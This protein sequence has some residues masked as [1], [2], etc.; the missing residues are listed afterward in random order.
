MLPFADRIRVVLVNTSAPGNIG[1][2]A[3]AMKTMGLSRLV[4]VAPDTY[5]HPEATWMAA[6]AGDVLEAAERVD[7]VADAIAG[8][9]LVIGT[10]ARDRRL[11]WPQKDAREMAAGLLGAG[12]EE[13]I[14]LLFGREDRG[15]SNEELQQCHWHVSIPANPDYGV[16]NIAQAVQILC[17]EIRM[18]WLSAEPAPAEQEWDVPWASAEEVEGFQ[19]HLE[20]TLLDIGFL[21]PERPRQLM[22]RLRRLFTRTRLD[23]M[24]VNILRGVLALVQKGLNKG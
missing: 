14:A 23:K 12:E 17:Y 3:R 7:S 20:Q 11:P 2:C 16:L 13:Q 10:S 6:N 15:L 21:D 24:E 22:P 4:L 9:T 19:R 1:A 5:P 8:C 18:A